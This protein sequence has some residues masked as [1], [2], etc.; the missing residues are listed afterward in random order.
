MMG[1][2]MNDAF[3]LSKKADIIEVDVKK[4][5]EGRGGIERLHWDCLQLQCS[6]RAWHEHASH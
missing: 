2:H 6:A 3:L 5:G 1:C 4:G